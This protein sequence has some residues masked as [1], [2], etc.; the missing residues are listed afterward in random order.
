MSERR[1]REKLVR[2]V[3][4][5]AHGLIGRQLVASLGAEGHETVALGR[6]GPGPTWDPYGGRL[7]PA[8]LAG[9]DAVVHLAGVGIAERR[10]SADQRRAVRDSRLIGTRLLAERLS[11]ASPRPRVLASASA[12][13]I[14]ADRGA[15]ELDEESLPG[16]GFLAELCQEWEHATEPATAAGMR[17]VHLRT[18]VVQSADGG[19]LARVLRLFRLGLGGR[20]GSG[21]QWMSWITLADEV[22]AIRFCLESDELAG[23]VDLTAPSPV[24]NAEYAAAL[25]RVLRR[26]TLLGIPRV[27]LEV[28][29]GAAL[30]DEAVLAS[31][32][33]LPRRLERAGF[34]F[35][36]PEIEAGLRRVLSSS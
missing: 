18:G 15:E 29:L 5:G 31:Q 22:R 23:A 10:W 32:R 25:G 20:L 2:V 14:Y 6:S 28:V 1:R 27:A 33:V 12:I 19:A 4:T 26:P 30:A 24:T 34:R 36:S 21:R 16:T 17:V 9:A 35:E 11:E 7:D 3:I 13:G 8:L